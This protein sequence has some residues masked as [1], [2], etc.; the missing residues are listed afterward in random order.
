[1]V[2]ENW[3]SDIMGRMLKSI[4]RNHLDE[5]KFFLLNLGIRM[6]FLYWNTAE[7]TD[8]VEYMHYNFFTDVQ[9]NP[10]YP[11]LIKIVHFFGPDI[12]TSGRFVSMLMASLCI[13]P[14]FHIAKEVYDKKTAIYS[15][16][17]FT[18]SPVIFGNSIRVMSDS[19]HLFF[20]LS[21]FYYWR[22]S[23][24]YY[25]ERD[26]ALF[27]FL[28][29]IA[30]HIRT[31]AIIFI[32][33]V[34]VILFIGINKSK[35]KKT[36]LLFL[37]SFTSWY[38]F[39]AQTIMKAKITNS[40][41]Y[42]ALYKWGITITTL[43]KFL[44]FFIA[45]VKTISFASTYPVFILFLFSIWIMQK[46]RLWDE[47]GLKIWLLILSYVLSTFLIGLSF[48][49]SWQPRFLIPV[50]PMVLIT[51]SFGTTKIEDYFK[52]KWVK[53]S[54]PIFCIV[55]GVVL[56][57]LTIV[58]ERDFFGD[59]RRSAE[60]IG[61]NC[62]QTPVYS[63]EITKISFWS[64]KKIHSY[65]RENVEVGQYITLHSYY[66]DLEKEIEILQYKYNIEILYETKSKVLSIFC[67]LGI[68]PKR[69][70][71]QVVFRDDRE[72]QEYKS[73]VLRIIS[74]K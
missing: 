2:I 14:I 65:K 9:R 13:F 68:A 30:I 50:I 52:K 1:M 17:F 43:P 3:H 74:L 24:L 45:Y 40:F 20:F 8:G 25:N 36:V 60:Y 63:D 67:L 26:M 22:K 53:L 39:V 41:G 66:I 61:E 57:M 33:L 28:S 56:T 6:F 27:I 51:G 71:Y 64:G 34:V 55:S 5:L 38:V 23:L 10:F 35:M 4:Y 46:Q 31:E 19:T 18:V 37:V 72:R 44:D 49:T 12:Q 69:E 11:F 59:V 7:F 70:E 62:K 21:S 48:H 32:P 15:C 16:L 73:L 47:K 58:A 29:G 42:L 54:I